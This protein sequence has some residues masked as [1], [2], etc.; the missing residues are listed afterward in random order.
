MSVTIVGLDSFIEG[1]SVAKQQAEPVVKKA[2]LALALNVRKLAQQKVA[3]KT[4]ILAQSITTE[5]LTYGAQT[6]VGEKYGVYLE[7][8]TGLF[9]PN[10]AHLIYSMSGGPLAWEADGE[11]HF[12][13]W[14]RGMEAQPYWEP[15]IRETEPLIEETMKA[16]AGE[17]I[18]MAVA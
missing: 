1:L 6:T 3:K 9:D 18:K 11:Q 13:M 5:P 7:Y 4:T 10:G 15:A 16:A 8:G 12:A 17:L 14:T 2:A